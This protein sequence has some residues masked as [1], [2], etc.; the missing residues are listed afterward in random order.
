MF[1]EKDPNKESVIL[2]GDSLLWKRIFFIMIITVGLVFRLIW[3]SDME[4]KNDEHIMFS[5]AQ[6]A[7]STHTLPAVGMKSGGGLVNPGL[8]VWGYAGFALFTNDPVTMDRMVQWVNVLSI[9][10]FLIFIL[11]RIDKEEQWLWM[12]GLA[13]ASVSPMA[14]IFSRKIWA[15]DLLPIVCFVVLLSHTYRNKRWGAF[16]WGLSGALIGQIHMSG[17]FFAAGLFV[18][19]LFYDRYNHNRFRWFWW[20][21]GSLLGSITLIPWI[22]YLVQN[23]QESTQSILHVLQFNFYWYWIL[24]SHGLNVYYSLGKNFRE[25]IKYPVVFG[26]PTYL[27]SLAHLFLLATL[28]ITLFE[29]GKFIKKIIALIRQKA[30]KAFLFAHDSISKLYLLSILLGL[31]ILLTLSGITVCPHYLICAFPLQYVFLSKIFN[32]KRKWFLFVIMAQMIITASFLFY[33]HTNNGA[34]KGDYWFSYKGQIT[35][36]K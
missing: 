14:V 11:Y 6:Q 35:A 34:P 12:A 29:I 32:K 13:L 9:L 27:V 1:V 17:F 30:F 26:F 25:F 31:G 16:I 20:L 23:P 28:G 5:M 36:N 2:P 24:D 18:F 3:T 7:A 8:S 15:Q 19:T 10:C 4:W 22:I 21:S 33:I